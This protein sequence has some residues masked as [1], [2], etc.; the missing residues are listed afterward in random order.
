VT[1]I[2]QQLG[3]GE[4]VA[5]ASAMSVQ[6]TVQHEIW[7]VREDLAAAY[8][9]FSIQSLSQLLPK[10]STSE[11]AYLAIEQGDNFDYIHAVLKL[12]LTKTPQ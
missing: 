10:G 9:D 2:Q 11:Y 8:S 3:Q 6:P 7:F 5:D 4:L 12:S 1:D